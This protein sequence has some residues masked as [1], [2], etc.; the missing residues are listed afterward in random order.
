VYFPHF[1]VQKKD[2]KKQKQLN[3]KNLKQQ[4]NLQKTL[5]QF[6][7]KPPILVQL[8]RE[9]QESTVQLNQTFP[10]TESEILLP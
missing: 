7:V 3:F 2:Q 8:P 10:S 1:K 5:T 4:L 9:Q 6:S